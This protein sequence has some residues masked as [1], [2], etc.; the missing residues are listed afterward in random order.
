MKK[1]FCLSLIL[2]AVVLAVVLLSLS[3]LEALAQN[4]KCYIAQG[5]SSVVAAS[6]CT[7]TFQSGSALTVASGATVTGLSTSTLTSLNAGTT[8]LSQTLTVTGATTLNGGLTMDTDALTV[9]D[10]SGNTQIKGTLGVT[11]ATTLN[12]N[13][14]LGGTLSLEGVTFSGP[15]K[16]GSQTAATSGITI[17][18]GLGTTPTSVII[19]P[20]WAG[21]AA[22]ITQTAYVSNV[23]ATT[24]A[25]E[26]TNGDLTQADVYW[27]AGR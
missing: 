13:T 10:T 20:S 15:V 22:T 25:I 4:V 1:R 3:N 16:F 26:F 12:G 11:G 23:N 17:T 27:M 19:I 2:S 5:G 6:G 18:H 21:A 24:F 7:Y 9:A 8:V 14:T